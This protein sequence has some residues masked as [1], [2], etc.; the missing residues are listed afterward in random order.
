MS[1]IHQIYWT[2]G[3]RAAARSGHDAPASSSSMHRVGSLD[4]ADLDECCRKLAP[5]VY[6]QLPRD[7][8]DAQRQQLDAGAAPRRLF[9]FSAPDGLQ[10]LGQ[11]CYC[12]AGARAGDGDAFA[13]V[14][15]E[16]ETEGRPRWPV[17]DC[18]KLWGASGWVEGSAAACAGPKAIQ[19][20][21]ELLGQSEPVIDDRVLWTFLCEPPEG[22]FHDPG[23]VLPARWRAM[24]A[25]ERGQWFLDVF[26]AF[27]LAGS[28]RQGPICVVAEPSVAA[29]LFYGVARLLPEGPVRDG[30]TFSTFEPDTAA[31][32]GAAL[33]G[34]WFSD[35]EGTGAS[36]DACEGCAATINTLRR[37]PEGQPRPRT[38]YATAMVQRLLDKG[39]DEVDWRLETLGAVK[40]RKIELLETV[41]GIEQLVEN[42]LATGSFANQ[43]WRKSEALTNSVRHV[44]LRHL[45]RARDVAAALKQV[46]GGPAHLSVL[47]LAAGAPKGAVARATVEFL[48]QRVPAE[49]FEILLKLPSVAPADKLQ[50]LANYLQARETLPPGCD[51]LW[52]EWEK[53]AKSGDPAKMGLLPQLLTTLSP[54]ALTKLYKRLPTPRAIQSVFGL[55]QLC[56]AKALRP[57][58]MTPVVEALDEDTLTTL[59][60]QHGTGFVE[61][62]PG[63]EPGMGRRLAALLKA[64]PYHPEEFKERLEWILAGQHLLEEDRDQRVATAWANC[65]K[66]INALG[67]LQEPDKSTSEQTRTNL[68]V[69]TAREMAI[70]ADEAMGSTAFEGENPHLRKLEC[71]RKIANELLGKPLL[72]PGPVEHE[73]LWTKIAQQLETHQWPVEGGLTKEA[74]KAEA[75]GKKDAKKEPGKK[76]GKEGAKK[77]TG[78]EARSLASTSGALTYLMVA[79][80]ALLTVAIVAACFYFFFASGTGKA[81]KKRRGKREVQPP[82]VAAPFKT[83]ADK[84]T[85]PKSTLR[86]LREK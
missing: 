25:T 13:H 44:L 39:W 82:K 10:V 33:V 45:E 73:F 83:D 26:S 5:Y 50:A 8:S 69:T 53:G 62:Y 7:L 2:L 51:A 32:S 9:R 84:G 11:A 52:A 43:N 49:K 72:P 42:V 28:D 12:P 61:E 75:S 17:L 40:V 76:E 22:A 65:R 78:P 68:L 80:V 48:L 56:N 20:L 23:R 29:L 15:F 81:T 30:V 36:I 3:V 86:D 67:R 19:S 74:M 24:P 31:A 54:E 35:P 64:L 21:G 57:T 16:R 59:F 47:D 27:L 18:L 70:A 6:Y 4:G 41:G 63:D 1:T 55:L 85:K 46:A 34:T 71:L 38:E 60:R 66:A 37:P 79:L 58:Q 77:L 14:L